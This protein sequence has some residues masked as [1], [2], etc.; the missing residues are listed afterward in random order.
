MRLGFAGSSS[1]FSVNVLLYL[2]KNNRKPCVIYAQSDK[3]KGRGLKKKHSKIKQISLYFNIRILQPSKLNKLHFFNVFSKLELDIF[4][5][6]GYGKI[7]PSYYFNFVSYGFFNMHPSLLPRWKG[8]NPIKYSLM[9]GDIISG[10]SLIKL[11]SLVD[12]G[13]ICYQYCYLI[14]EL[15]ESTSLEKKLSCVAIFILD[16]FLSKKKYLQG[17]YI[18][19]NNK[20]NYP[21]A[22]KIFKFSNSVWGK[23]KTNILLYLKAYH[24]FPGIFFFAKNEAIKILQI[25]NYKKNINNAK[26]YKLGEVVKILKTGIIFKCQNGFLILKKI[27]ISGKN[28]V[29]IED[30]VNSNNKI[31]KDNL[32]FN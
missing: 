30:Y 23:C 14:K 13:D 4:I 28:E 15:D 17:I 12:K 24:N 11:S 18:S 2:I 26:V 32:I 25:E 1:K 7:V 16:S 29:L 3:R 5:I 20:I 10:V 9:S 31:I 21:N 27:Q 6:C 22:D 19:Q 8:A